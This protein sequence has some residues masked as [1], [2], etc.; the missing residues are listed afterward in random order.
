LK[1]A[2]FDYHAPETLEEVVALKA[3]LGDEAKIL[4]GG[5]SLVPSMNFRLARPSALIDINRVDAARASVV[6]DD[7][8]VIS[9]VV[10]H[11][12]FEAPRDLG[13]TG[14]LLASAC[15]H[16]GHHPIRTRGTFVGSVAHADPAAEWSV[17]TLATEALLR[18]RA[19]S[20][21]RTI[22]SSEFFVGPYMTALA[23]DEVL[24][25]A[26][27]P[28]LSPSTK[29]SFLELSRRAGDFALVCVAVV[30]DESGGVLRD[31]RI[32]LGGVAS[33]PVRVPNAEGALNGEVPSAALFEEAARRAAGEINT[34]GDIHGSAEYRRELISVYVR[35]GLEQAFLGSGP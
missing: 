27:V 32:A 15:K 33:R 6:T 3:E 28:L 25:E 31:V 14:V 19:V 7:H 21:E 2:K 18:A 4:A 29:F 26:R 9:P 24:V 35:R 16:I 10:R 34:I 8:I 11:A 17:V 22:S 30:G 5:Q 20:G 13:P 23:D 12:H 1:A